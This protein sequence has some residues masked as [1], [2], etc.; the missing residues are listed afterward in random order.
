MYLLFAV[1]DCAAVY[2]FHHGI[3]E[4][5]GVYAQIVLAFQGQA[6]GVGYGAYAQ[7]DAGSVRYLLGDEI[8]Y[9]DAGLIQHGRG[10]HRQLEAVFHYSVHPADVYLC[11]AHGSGLLV[12]HLQ[13]YAL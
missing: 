10:Q 2:Q 5:L 8:A 6:G 12:V 1:I 9:G 11:A 4:H 7:L 13:E 3:G